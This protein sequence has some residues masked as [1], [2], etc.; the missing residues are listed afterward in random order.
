MN[1]PS[2]FFG[3]YILILLNNGNNSHMLTYV[4]GRQVNRNGSAI[5]NNGFGKHTF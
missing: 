1:I 5:G 4:I 2:L 3:K